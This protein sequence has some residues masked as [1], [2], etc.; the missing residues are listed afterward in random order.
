MGDLIRPLGGASSNAEYLYGNRIFR[1]Y[2]WPFEKK[3]LPA[4]SILVTDLLYL[5][6]L[7][8]H[9]YKTCFNVFS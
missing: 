1:K 2:I 4:C 9:V 5:V 8:C 6:W 3:A 7:F